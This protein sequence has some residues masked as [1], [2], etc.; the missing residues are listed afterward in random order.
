M[1]WRCLSQ[2]GATQ[3]PAKGGPGFDS[4]K[5]FFFRIFFGFFCRFFAKNF[6]RFLFILITKNFGS[7]SVFFGF[8]THLY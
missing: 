7:V 3:W 4:A 5:G 2:A 8:G 1:F 6:G